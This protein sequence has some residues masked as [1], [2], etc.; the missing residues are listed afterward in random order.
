ML[1]AAPSI[2]FNDSNLGT[3]AVIA[4]AGS[5]GT[6]FLYFALGNGIGAYPFQFNLTTSV[7]TAT[8]WTSTSDI[9]LKF[10]IQPLL[11]GLDAL[12]AL[13]VFTYMQAPT[14]EDVDAGNGIFGAG[15]MA[16][17][18]IGTPFEGLV[19]QPTEDPWGNMGYYAFNYTGLTAWYI[20]AFKETKARLEATEAAL[21]DVLSRLAAA[22]L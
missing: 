10:D 7:A 13:D 12:T 2:A 19:V 15:V 18:L 11:S 21:A 6:S 16:Q 3:K 14:E 22:G 5:T 17:D 4:H 20:A 8:T 1:G 9:R